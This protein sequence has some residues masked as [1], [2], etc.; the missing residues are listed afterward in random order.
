MGMEGVRGTRIDLATVL[1]MTYEQFGVCEQL[2]EGELSPLEVVR[3]DGRREYERKRCQGIN[4]GRTGQ[5]LSVSSVRPSIRASGSPSE[6]IVSLC[7][8]SKAG[9]THQLDAKHTMQTE[10]S[11]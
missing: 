7:S 2:I 6:V 5:Y 8:R 9:P 1:I 10:C 11:P 3:P 4:E